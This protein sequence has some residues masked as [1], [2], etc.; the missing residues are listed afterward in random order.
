MELSF[1]VMPSAMV[2]VIF[3]ASLRVTVDVDLTGSVHRFCFADVH[4]AVTV[5]RFSLSLTLLY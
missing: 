1:N 4:L 3:N 2:M 5:C